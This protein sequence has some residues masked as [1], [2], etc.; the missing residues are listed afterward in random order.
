MAGV[1]LTVAMAALAL[2]GALAT[3]AHADPLNTDASKTLADRNQ[4][5]STTQHKTFEWDAAKSRWGLK[6]D[7]EQQAGASSE[8]KNVQAGAFFKLTPSLR[9]GAGVS[10]SDT[11]NN[12]SNNPLAQTPAPPRVHLETAFKF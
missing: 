12:P 7:V 10:L 1:K 11:Q 4:W 6:F 2:S 5:A 3:V 8:Y 9:V